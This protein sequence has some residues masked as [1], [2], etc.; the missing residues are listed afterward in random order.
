MFRS[1]NTS[2]HMEGNVMEIIGLI[3]L[4]VIGSVVVYYLDL[5][6]TIWSALKGQY[7]SYK[8]EQ[9]DRETKER[10]YIKDRKT[11]A[12]KTVDAWK[13][14]RTVEKERHFSNAGTSFNEHF[15]KIK[16]HNNGA[17][18]ITNPDEFLSHPEVQRQ[19]KGMQ[20][21]FRRETLRALHKGT[22]PPQSFGEGSWTKERLKKEWDDEWQADL[23][24]VNLTHEQFF[25]K[26][27]DQ[28]VCSPRTR[29]DSDLRTLKLD[30]QK[31]KLD[32]EKEFVTK[33]KK[34]VEILASQSK[35]SRGGFK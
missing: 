7:A 16:I 12:Q 19:L 32:L 9:L 4:L 3:I 11:K 35:S 23:E 31:Q 30:L 17:W 15:D 1:W 33:L 26:S 22:E 2:H 25:G 6:T 21:L 5:H 13:E 28:F 24:A 10:T 27:K 34:E 14:L 29:L 8:Q 18:S 20:Q